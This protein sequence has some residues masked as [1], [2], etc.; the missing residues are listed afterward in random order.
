MSWDSTSPWRSPWAVLGVALALRIA[1]APGYASTDM[2]VHR[3][4]L[5]VTRRRPLGEW[6]WESTSQ[7]TL[8]YPPLF[9]YAQ[10][11][12]GAV[13]D[14]V[15]PQAVQVRARGRGGGRWGAVPPQPFSATPTPPRLLRSC[16]PPPSLSPRACGGSCGGAW[17]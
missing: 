1:L 11:A 3:N 5:A 15:C 14:A 17:W 10:W 13:A 16:Q 7:W 9:A 12:L 2:E 6:Y 8:D 4:W